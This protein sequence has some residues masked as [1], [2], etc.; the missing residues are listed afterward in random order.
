MHKF[1]PGLCRQYS[2]SW[3]AQYREEI[4]V[5]A[6]FSAPVLPLESTQ[7]PIQR[8][9]G[10]SWSK[11]AGACI[12][13]KWHDFREKVTEYKMCVLISSTTFISNISHSKKISARYCHKFENVF[14]QNT[15]YFC[16]IL[17][18]LEFSQQIFDVK[19]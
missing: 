11:V 4:L 5:W 16:H 6:K 18:K 10:H 12:N 8:V 2:N 13:H 17:T 7:P 14:M 3:A 1:G 19:Y 9:P 15:C